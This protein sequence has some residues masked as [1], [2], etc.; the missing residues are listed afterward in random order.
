MSSQSGLG[1]VGGFGGVY[2]LTEIQ[3][4]SQAWWH[5]PL[6]PVFQKVEAGRSLVQE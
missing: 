4:R 1:G 2:M 6:I 3:T 5:R